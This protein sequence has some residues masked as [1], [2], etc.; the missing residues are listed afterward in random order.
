MRA[1]HPLSGIII[2]PFCEIIKYNQ[3]VISIF[4]KM[5]GFV[6]VKKRYAINEHYFSGRNGQ[7][8]AQS[9]NG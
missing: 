1:I 7:P 5:F 9:E 4:Q 8:G 6:V 2:A 3:R